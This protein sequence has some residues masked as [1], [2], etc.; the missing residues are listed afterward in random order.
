MQTARPK[1]RTAQERLFLYKRNT[2]FH[3]VWILVPETGRKLRRRVLIP[4]TVVT[5]FINND[6][7]SKTQVAT[8][9]KEKPGGLNHLLLGEESTKMLIIEIPGV[10]LEFC[11]SSDGGRTWKTSDGGR[12][13]NHSTCSYARGRVS[14]CVQEDLH[15]DGQYARK[16]IPFR[17]FM[18]PL[19]S[20]PSGPS[21]PFHPLCKLLEPFQAPLESKCHLE[22]HFR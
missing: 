16:T 1:T 6:I 10:K 2:I 7:H 5:F 9:C 12:T 11:P 18:C 3:F 22:T 17:E 8:Y 19:S 13:W 20:Y 14:P 21:A 4:T 15:S